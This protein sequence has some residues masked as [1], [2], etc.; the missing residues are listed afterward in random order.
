MA[1]AM[2]VALLSVLS[3]T[4]L[5]E[6]EEPP[7]RDP[8]EAWNRPVHNFNETLDV[9]ILQPVARGYR[10]VTPR[11]VE[12]AVAN[13]FDN[14]T[15]PLSIVGGMLQ[16][17]PER[18]LTDTGRFV[19]NSTIGVGGLFDPASSMGLE[20]QQEDIGQALESWGLK[21]SPYLVLPFLGPTTL[22]QIPDRVIAPLV[23]PTLMGGYWH[24]SLW[25]MD[26]LS[27]RAE[28]L[29]GSALLDEASADSYIF[30]REAFL[31]RRRFLLYDGEPPIDDFDAF[32]DDF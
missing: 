29:A 12:R 27:T 7:D 9:N 13:F 14:L 3:V 20:H 11:P 23:G 2:V 21:H 30:T 8:F 10:A 24:E 26:F 19:V 4:A 25:A 18:M 5:A 17:N 15:L 16:L 32:F 1:C 22:V 6:A 31:Q 28:L